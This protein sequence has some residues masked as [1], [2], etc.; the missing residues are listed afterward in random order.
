[1]VS[2]FVFA[3]DDEAEALSRYIRH[4]SKYLRYR[5]QGESTWKSGIFRLLSPPGAPGPPCMNPDKPCSRA[6]V[7]DAWALAP[8]A[9]CVI[10]AHSQPSSTLHLAIIT[11]AM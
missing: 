3:N 10:S 2:N 4:P 9:S 7:G 6:R 11:A 1:M 8:V 5:G